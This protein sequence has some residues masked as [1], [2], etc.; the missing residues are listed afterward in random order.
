M[1]VR[2]GEPLLQ[3]GLHPIYLINSLI[4][5]YLTVLPD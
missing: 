2:F 3:T 4:E 1:T 5:E